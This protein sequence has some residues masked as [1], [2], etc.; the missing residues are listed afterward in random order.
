MTPSQLPDASYQQYLALQRNIVV[1]M[2]LI[3]AAKLVA[4]DAVV[5][6]AATL[7][8]AGVLTVA[9]S[10]VA[11]RS[12][13]G[14]L[15]NRVTTPSEEEV[16][17]LKAYAHCG[18]FVALTVYGSRPAAALILW[19][20]AFASTAIATNVH[21]SMIA[22]DLGP[23]VPERW[24]AAKLAGPQVGTIIG[25][26]IAL[27]T[28]ALLTAGGADPLIARAGAGVVAALMSFALVQQTA[29]ARGMRQFSRPPDDRRPD[30]PSQP[31]SA[32]TRAASPSLPSRRAR[33]TDNRADTAS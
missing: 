19:F 21:L 17:N 11:T 14:F 23:S 29:V 15:L 9:T 16:V 6:V 13:T 30:N 26:T 12:G 20:V 28:A 2:A 7:W 8:F 4:D 3:A 1:P 31:I 24:Y 27:F 33:L 10:F 32:T 18:A 25:A 22:K 5:S